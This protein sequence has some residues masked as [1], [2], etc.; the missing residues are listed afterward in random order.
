MFQ[1][2]LLPIPYFS[3]SET[4]DKLP[5]TAFTVSLQ[6]G[7][8][9]VS[10]SIC[11]YKKIIII[12]LQQGLCIINFIFRTWTLYILLNSTMES[13]S[14]LWRAKKYFVYNLNITSKILKE[15]K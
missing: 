5:R 7:S 12:N 14:K 6:L 13:E 1:S 8:W 4:V 3:V 15:L 11:H 9:K 2:K 10:I